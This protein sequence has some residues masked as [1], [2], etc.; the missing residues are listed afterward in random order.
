MWI[1]INIKQNKLVVN[2]SGK[3]HDPHNIEQFTLFTDLTELLI[4]SI[5]GIE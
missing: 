2:T 4:Q 1:L 3:S 5:P